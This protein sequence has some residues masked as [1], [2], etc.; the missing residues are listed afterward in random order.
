MKGSVTTGRGW[1]WGTRFLVAAE[2]RCGDG[3]MGEMH[4]GRPVAA[5]LLDA[6]GPPALPR[7]CGVTSRLPRHGSWAQPR[8]PS[9]EKP[10]GARCGQAGPWA[11]AHP[12]QLRAAQ[13]TDPHRCPQAAPFLTVK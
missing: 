3:L 5:L 9:A 12:A 1:R 2:S 10:G 11:P 13:G 8:A 6:P 4:E 7:G